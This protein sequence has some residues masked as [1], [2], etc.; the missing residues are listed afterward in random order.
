MKKE[1]DFKKGK[2]GAVAKPDAK[3]MR[4]IRL[5]L[6][7]LTWLLQEADRTRIP[8]QTLINSILKQEMDRRQIM[9]KIEAL[10]ATDRSALVKKLE[11][12]LG[13]VLTHVPNKRLKEN[14]G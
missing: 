9:G 11:E 3:V 13:F 2:R 10:E 12:N 6:D 7:V 14:S 5:D 4:T 8:Y 1:Y